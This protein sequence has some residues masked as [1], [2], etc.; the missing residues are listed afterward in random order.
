METDNR[1]HTSWTNGKGWLY[2]YLWTFRIT[3]CNRVTFLTQPPPLFS[4]VKGNVLP[5]YHHLLSFHLDKW[6]LHSRLTRTL[7]ISPKVFVKT[8]LFRSAYPPRVLSHSHS[9]RILSSFSLN[10]LNGRCLLMKVDLNHPI[11]W[12]LVRIILQTNP[13]FRNNFKICEYLE[14]ILAWWLTRDWDIQS[15]ER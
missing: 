13:I 2:H 11:P 10:M 14:Y 8:I 9:Y 7:W 6:I 15:L 4:L 3:K 5:P 12:D 1:K